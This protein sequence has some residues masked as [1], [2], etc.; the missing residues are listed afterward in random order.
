LFVLNF[1]EDSGD[2]DRFLVAVRG[3]Q[4]GQLQRSLFAGHHFAFLSAVVGAGHGLNG[5]A[6][7]RFGVAF[8][9]GGGRGAA[10]RHVDSGAERSAAHRREDRRAEG[11]AG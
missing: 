9:F 10:G 1:G 5:F 2:V 7:G 3:L 4:D 8:R 6:V 11:Q